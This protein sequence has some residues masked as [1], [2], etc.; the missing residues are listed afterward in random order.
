MIAV[1]GGL[2]ISPVFGHSEW[3]GVS[4]AD[5]LCVKWIVSWSF[6]LWPKSHA[7]VKARH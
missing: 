5:V 2:V 3:F 1:N 4:A 7:Q 6:N